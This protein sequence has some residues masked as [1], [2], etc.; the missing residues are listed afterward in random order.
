MRPGWISSFSKRASGGLSETPVFPSL[1]LILAAEM[2]SCRKSYAQAQS[3]CQSGGVGVTPTESLHAFP[4]HPREYST[5][6]SDLV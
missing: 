5:G 6:K 3:V 1:V 4:S 2:S